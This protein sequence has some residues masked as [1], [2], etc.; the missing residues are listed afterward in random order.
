MTV[1]NIQSVIAT[2]ISALS[3]ILDQNNESIG[4]KKEI[5]ENRSDEV[6][7]ELYNY[8][9]TELENYYNQQALE[10]FSIKDALSDILSTYLT[11]KRETFAGHRL[12]NLV[13][14][15]IP[16]E[17]RNLPFIHS[18]LKITGSVGQG[19]WATIPWIAIMDKRITETTRQGEYLVYLFSE[20]MKS[21]Y[22]TFIKV[23]LSQLRQK[24][25]QQPTN[26]SNK[27]S[28]KYV[29]CSHLKE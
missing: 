25:S 11:A 13:R 5:Y 29:T 3:S 7:S 9:Q 24:V 28:K 6:L 15:L 26:I 23:L 1:I 18:E 14:Q 16:T 20:D 10:S 4:F 21:V 8:A 2:P 22:L 17:L 27:K 19:N 12:G